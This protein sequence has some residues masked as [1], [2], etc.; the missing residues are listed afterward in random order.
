M[1]CKHWF[2]YHMSI[3]EYETAR[4]IITKVHQEKLT[5]MNSTIM[6]KVAMA[7]FKMIF[8][9]KVFT[10][11]IGLT[12]VIYNCFNSFNTVFYK[13]SFSFPHSHCYN[14]KILQFSRQYILYSII[15][16]FA[17]GHGL[18]VQYN[19]INKFSKNWTVSTIYIGYIG[20]NRLIQVIFSR[21]LH[22]VFPE[23]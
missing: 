7:Q 15:C 13:F 19:I 9:N 5:A 6:L 14:T 21:V 18:S 16:C 10:D 22:Q 3:S 2:L 12:S 4:Q 23:L 11:F 17:S 20:W 8:K 1:C